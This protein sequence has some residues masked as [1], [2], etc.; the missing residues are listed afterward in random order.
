MY[1]IYELQFCNIGVCVRVCVWVGECAR[2][3]V[4]QLDS[5]AKCVPALTKE[6]GEHKSASLYT[7]KRG[8][9]NVSITKTIIIPYKMMT[10]DENPIIDQFALQKARFTNFFILIFLKS[11]Q[12]NFL[13]LIKITIK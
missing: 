6:D 1:I 12:S 3:R 7:V 11:H 10:S 4:H 9:I 2:T 8:I 13:F 5:A